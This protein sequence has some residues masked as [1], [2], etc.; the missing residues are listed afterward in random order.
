MPENQPANQT[1][2]APMVA[3]STPAT[4]TPV[5][6]AQTTAGTQAPPP[7]VQPPAAVQTQQVAPVQQSSP[8]VT[9]SVA[10]LANPAVQEDLEAQAPATPAAAAQSAPAAATST[11]LT[12]EKS[13]AEDG[14]APKSVDQTLEKINRGFK[15]RATIEKAKQLNMQYINISV[16]PINPDLLKLL[17]PETVKKGLIMP[18][19]KIGKK[20]RIAVADPENP[21]TK[22]ALQELIGKGYEL[23][24][25]L[26]SDDGIL[27]AARLYEGEQYKI[28]KAMDTS[29]SEDKIKAYEQEIQQ[30]E[31]LKTRLPN[32][33]SEEAVYLIS[34]GAL[35]TGASDMHME[36]D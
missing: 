2:P 18:F 14:K 30:L 28:K 23:N 22:A 3:E 10:S 16:T 4:G 31:D 21:D 11:P 1:P 36:P 15:E 12:K 7:A 29:L 5:P 20:V 25:N 32:I 33:S 26:A 24:I 6:A 19:F 35:K 9:P 17:A 13:A 27:E 8:T 34:V